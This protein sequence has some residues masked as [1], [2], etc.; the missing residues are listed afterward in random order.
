MARSI[1]TIFNELLVAKAAKAELSG[2]TSTSAVSVWRLLLYVVAVGIWTMEKLFDLHLAEVRGI[3]ASQKRGTVQWYAEMAKRFQFG[4]ALVA[5]QDYYDNTGVSDAVV[6]A[7]KVVAFAA[8]TESGSAI[9]IKVARL[10]AGNLA[11]LTAPQLAA[12]QTYM[13]R[14]KYAGAF[15]SFV[16]AVADSLKLDLKIYYD[17]LV[18]DSLGK[19]ID[20]TNDTPVQSTIDDYLINK[21]AFDSYYVPT[22]LV[23]ALQGVDG[24]KLP[25][26]TGSAARYGMLSFSD[27]GDRYLPDAGYLRIAPADLTITFIPY[28]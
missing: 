1:D 11:P 21:I 20:G 12:F 17:P 6:A 16:N 18:L 5:D 19:R 25:V 27:T 23:D 28:L 10:N 24:V 26:I 4:D 9:R 7:K 13:A 14:I 8:A 15:L 22:A 3:I 2:L